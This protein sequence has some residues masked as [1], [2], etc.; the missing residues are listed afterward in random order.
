[1]PG[2]RHLDNIDAL[3]EDERFIHRHPMR[4]TLIDI[5]PS[6]WA[7]FFGEQRLNVVGDGIRMQKGDA[8]DV[9]N[10]FLFIDQENP[11]QV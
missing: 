7:A 5:N 8:I 3:A 9:A 1:M 6:R 2:K 10:P 11:K 4:Q